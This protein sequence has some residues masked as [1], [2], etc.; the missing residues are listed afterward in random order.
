MPDGMTDLSNSM[1]AFRSDA[2]RQQVKDLA[3][4]HKA[5]LS[6]IRSRINCIDDQIARLRSHRQQLR[7]KRDQ[8]IKHI[9]VLKSIL[10]PFRRVPTDVLCEI[11]ERCLP[12][13]STGGIM[14]VP[15]NCDA[16]LLLCQVCSE[17]RRTALGFPPLWKS[18]A[19]VANCWYDLE[20]KVAMSVRR[21]RLTPRRVG[22]EPQG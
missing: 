5:N 17:W 19:L 20:T 12:E 11:F 4:S 13:M 1:Q 7:F 3:T 21:D 6:T 8:E 2:E 15:S 16:P 10:S 22:Y 9:K 14:N 18:V